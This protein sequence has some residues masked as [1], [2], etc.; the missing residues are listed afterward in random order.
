MPDFKFSKIWFLASTMTDL[1]HLIGILKQVK[2][3]YTSYSIYVTFLRIFVE[4]QENKW[5][6][7]L[8]VDIMTLRLHREEPVQVTNVMAIL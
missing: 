2:T 1:Q 5:S 4:C 3:K 6:R 8:C 7:L